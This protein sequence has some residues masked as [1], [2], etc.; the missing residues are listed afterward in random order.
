MV[1]INFF[2][3]NKNKPQDVNEILS[4][5][6]KLEKKTEEL[7][8]ELSAVR[9]MAELSI[10]KVSVIR[11]NPFKDVG[12]DQSFSIALLDFENNGF[13]ISSI[14][15]REGSKIYTKP[16]KNGQSEYALSEEEE[17]AIK[18]ALGQK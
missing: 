17:K 4:Y 5:V 18:K 13:V 6:K 14:F 11:F 10:Q 9:K 16:V 1:G 15:M 2:K 3:K 7:S 8:E 12:G